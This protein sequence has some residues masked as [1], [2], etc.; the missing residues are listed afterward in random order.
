MMLCRVAI[1][2]AVVASAMAPAWVE[3]QERG[4]I[5]RDRGEYVER[6]TR[7]IQVAAGGTLEIDTDAGAIEVDTWDKDEVQIVI[8]KWGD[9]SSD[10]RAEELFDNFE[11]YIDSQGDDVRIRG[12]QLRRRRRNYLNVTFNVTVPTRSNVELESGGGHIEIGDLAGDVNARSAGGHIEVGQV[13]NGSVTVETAGGHLGIAG[14]NGGDLTAQ[15]AGGHV[16]VGDV[17]GRLLIKT[18]GGAIEIDHCGASVRAVTAGGSIEV[19]EV[20]GDLEVS[21]SGGSIRVGHAGGDVEASTSGGGIR[22]GECGGSAYLQTSGGNISVDEVRGP[23]QAD[24]AG[25]SIEVEA[26]GSGVEAETAGGDI[27]VGFTNL[28]GAADLASRLITAD[29]DITIFLPE[30]MAATIDA[31]LRLRHNYGRGYRI[32]SDFPLVMRGEGSRRVVGRGDMNG[33]GDLI[34]LKARNGDIHI[35]RVRSTR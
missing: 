35:E 26:A 4:T 29:G 28:A 27:E 15:T 17:T 19:R 2:A 11:I 16:T 31:E 7:T 30:D 24:T 32:Y 34:E 20:A 21:T 25:G 33:G 9:V 23:L 5:E 22:L 3:A 14:V 1:V 18:S 13:E 6:I 8:E 12:D 10:S